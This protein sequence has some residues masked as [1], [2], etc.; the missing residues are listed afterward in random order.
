MPPRP[1]TAAVLP[2]NSSGRGRR[3]R[4]AL[5]QNVVQVARQ[6]QQKSQGVVGHFRTLDDL[7]VGQDDIAVHEPFGHELFDA[8]AAHVNPAQAPSGKL[9]QM[10]AEQR[11]WTADEGF[12]A[13][14]SRLDCFG[15]IRNDDPI[16]LRDRGLEFFRP[17]RRQ[18]TRRDQQDARTRM[19]RQ[20]LVA[21][22]R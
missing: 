21:A 22:F 6:R 7:T 12:G 8:G 14:N 1:N 15:L 10:I 11:P 16:R 19:R 5:T 20:R 17:L 4:A 9:K 2:R 13:G 18:P 3:T